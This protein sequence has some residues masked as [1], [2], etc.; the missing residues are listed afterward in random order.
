M[1]PRFFLLLSLV[2]YGWPAFSQQTQQS[3]HT[4]TRQTRTPLPDD[5]IR[6][7]DSSLRYL[8]SRGLFNGVVL[9]ARQ[10]R[11]R[12]Q[13]ALGQTGMADQ[14]PL[15]IHSSFNLAAVSRQ[16]MAM[17][18]MQL[19][20]QGHIRYDQPVNDILPDF[21]YTG[22][23]IRHL[24]THTSGL[25]EYAELAGRYSGPLDTLTNQS[26]LELLSVHKPALQFTPGQQWRDSNT[27]YVLLGSVIS[28]VTGKPVEDVF[29]HQIVRPLR[30]NDTYIVHY[31]P[32]QINRRTDRVMGFTRYNGVLQPNDLTRFD[33]AV[34]DGNVYSSAA[35]LFLWEQALTANTLV[36]A[37]TMQE[38]LTPVRLTDGTTYPYGFGWELENGQQSVFSHTGTR[39][40]FYNEIVRYVNDKQT[41]IVLSNGTNQVARPLIRQL[42]EGKSVRLPKTQLITNVRLIDGTGIPA[43]PAAVR[44][45]DQTIREVGQLSPFPDE[46]VTDGKGLVLA[47]GF[48]DSHSH[49]YASLD[50]TPEAIAMVS[51]GITTI[52]IGQD[53]S[54]YPIDTLMKRMSSSPVAVNVATYT[55]H[56]T[57]RTH[58]MGSRGLYRT[59]RP[60]EIDRMKAL[61][62]NDMQLGSLGLATGLEY[63]SA[64]FSSRDE[65]LQLAQ[66]A[67][68]AGGRYMSH[69]RSEDISFADAMDEIIAI[70]RQTRMPVQISHIKL[71]Q[72]SQWGQ[73]ADWLA[74]LEKARAE[75]INITADCYP[76][77]FWLSTLRV[78]FPKRDYTNPESARFA[79]EQL[80]D[81]EKSILA[82]FNANPAYA[83]RTL[84]EIARTRQ[85]TTAQTLMGLVAEA[86]AHAEKH[87]DE[88]GE[89]IMGKSMDEPDLIR[90]LQWPHTNIC[91]DGSVGGHPR[92]FGAFT[93][94]LGRYVRE[95]PIMPLEIAVYKMTG[96]TAQHLG[97]TDRGIVAPGYAADLVLFNPD[98]VIDKATP[99]NSRLP[100]AGIEAV[101]VSGQPV[102]IHQQPTGNFPGVFI[103][104]K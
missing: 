84:G 7:L 18:V 62:R 13:Q 93:R 90:F 2:F 23:T 40:G 101:W 4:V 34:G 80:F 74:Q 45:Q 25:P 10:G 77:D 53:G 87:P 102:F 16:F 9:L 3:R 72:R 92:A 65:V 63:E 50:K 70:G 20:E 38:A 24:L 83:G 79:V 60:Q 42:V 52:V 26:L 91:S 1:K 94:V 51:Q 104:R 32:Q 78:L 54:S 8:H 41:L 82:R 14:K 89:S 31:Q 36:S 75:G 30:L 6:R 68:D 47:P 57:L 56:S 76:Y 85:E 33:G 29:E 96:L 39:G 71:A 73:A 58:V 69:I 21:P 98:T 55:G 11:I 17:L 81:P 86:A 64:F 28:A 49:H 5:R 46:A 67:A 43:R 66:V 19:N 48:I 37:A 103:R 15:T 44:I 61:L 22:I 100:G 35:D 97:L 88:A 95:Q 12:Y 59:A 99:G 27:G